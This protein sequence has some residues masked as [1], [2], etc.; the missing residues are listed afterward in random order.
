[1]AV[2]ALNEYE[3]A[4]MELESTV[5][6]FKKTIDA[7]GANSRLLRNQVDDMNED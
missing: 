5:A 1:M 6:I 4:L 3:G 7:N 2:A